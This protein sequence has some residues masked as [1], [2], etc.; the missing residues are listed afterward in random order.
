[1]A[2]SVALEDVVVAR[3]LAAPAGWLR[4]WVATLNPHTPRRPRIWLDG[5]EVR[6]KD[7][8]LAREFR[9]VDMKHGRVFSG[10]VD[11]PCSSSDVAHRVCVEVMTRKG[12]LEPVQLVTRTLPTQVPQP[13]APRADGGNQPWDAAFNVLL[14]SCYGADKDVQVSE[15]VRTIR[16]STQVDLVLTVGDQVYLDQPL[17]K[18]E[19]HAFADRFMHGLNRF[20]EDKYWRNWSGD[21]RLNPRG[22]NGL[23]DILQLAPVAAI[24]D[25]HEYWNNYP[26]PSPLATPASMWSSIRTAWSSAAKALYDSYQL[27]EDL[28]YDYRVDVDPLSFWM[29]DNRTFREEDRGFTLQ[30]P[31]PPFLG[32]LDKFNQ[33]IDD[34]IKRRLVPV[35]VTGPSIVQDEVGKWTG[36]LTDYNFVNFRDYPDIVNQL[37]RAAAA[38]LPVLLL[39]GDVHYGRVVRIDASA[40]GGAAAYGDRW[41]HEVI[42][43]PAALV[44]PLVRGSSTCGSSTSRGGCRSPSTPTPT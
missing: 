31:A 33:W 32:G 28:S 13:G 8:Q 23:A 42:S 6:L 20:L 9:R 37:L 43:S 19:Y 2:G 24:P 11:L 18:A 41:I 7:Q 5:E 44:N 22:R 30:Q 17:L 27:A 1:M 40:G 21:P 29:M 10:V 38:D 14:V 25:D 39:T 34:V 36:R 4:I 3:P 15:V 12:A 35:L 26:G 16:R